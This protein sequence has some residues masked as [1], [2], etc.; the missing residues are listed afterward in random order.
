LRDEIHPHLI[1]SDI[2]MSGGLGFELLW[3]ERTD[4]VRVPV[5]LM[6]AFPT[7]E[8]R[9]FAEAAGVAFLAK[10]FSFEKLRALIRTVL[11][12]PVG[13]RLVSFDFRDGAP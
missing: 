2:R 1:V 13:H 3:S 7:P 11:S 10:P 4:A 12:N 8:L 5:V 9:E 6:T